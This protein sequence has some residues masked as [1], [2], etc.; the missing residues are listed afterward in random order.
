[1]GLFKKKKSADKTIEDRELVEFNSDSISTLL[2]FTENNEQLTSQ[3][4][5]LQDTLKYLIPSSKSEIMDYDKKIKNKIGDLKIALTKSDGE[6][7]SKATDALQEIKI[8]I[9]ERNTRL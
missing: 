6:T 7:S 2:V 1:M 9:S 8:A 5:D 4:K 3:L